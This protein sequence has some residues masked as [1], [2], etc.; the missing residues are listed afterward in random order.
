MWIAGQKC[1]LWADDIDNATT[2][3]TSTA[4][5]IGPTPWLV[6]ILSYDKN[7]N[8]VEAVQIQDFL[9]V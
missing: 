3:Q 9:Q 1:Q 7:F 4:N 5:A 2:T 6:N 8:I